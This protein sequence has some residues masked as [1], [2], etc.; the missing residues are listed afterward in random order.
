[1]PGGPAAFATMSIFMGL[2]FGWVTKKTGSIRW[3]TAAHILAD[4]M[5]LAGFAFVGLGYG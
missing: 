2:V 1:M 4:F 3:T 5:G